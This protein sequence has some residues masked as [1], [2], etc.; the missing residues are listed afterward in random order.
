MQIEGVL[1]MGVGLEV[2]FHGAADVIEVALKKFLP[3]V[4]NRVSFQV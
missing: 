2:G 4:H 1:D 3:Q